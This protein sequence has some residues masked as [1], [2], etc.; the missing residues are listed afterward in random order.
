MRCWRDTE[1]GGRAA[2]KENS[3]KNASANTDESVRAE[4][5]TNRGPSIEEHYQFW[6]K[7]W[8]SERPSHDPAREET[9]RAF[10][11]LKESTPSGRFV[12]DETSLWVS[13]VEMANW[14]QP[15]RDKLPTFFLKHFRSGHHCLSGLFQRVV[16]GDADWPEELAEGV[17]ALLPKSDAKTVGDFRPI[18]LLPTMLKCLSRCLDKKLREH[19]NRFSPICQGCGREGARG[20]SDCVLV[21]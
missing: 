14:K 2:K 3:G 16:D 19:L 4:P 13:L 11:K 8:G 15:G 10:Q 7:L 1:R 5:E 20:V 18:N 21:D 9:K 17:T 12:V 6:N